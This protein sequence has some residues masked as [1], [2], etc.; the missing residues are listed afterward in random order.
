MA[1]ARFPEPK[2]PPL[3]I[4]PEPTEKPKAGLFRRL[5]RTLL[6]VALIG[7]IAFVLYGSKKI[8]QDRGTGGWVWPTDWTQDELRGVW[9]SAKEISKEASERLKARID[10]RRSRHA[11][12]KKKKDEALAEYEKEKAATG[13]AGGTL[14]PAGQ[15]QF[16]SAI[17]DMRDG[18]ALVDGI[19]GSGKSQSE[20]QADLRQ[21]KDLLTRAKKNFEEGKAKGLTP[22]AEKKLPQFTEQTRSYIE[23]VDSM[24]L[25]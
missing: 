25:Q 15:A 19:F 4:S 16:D 22:A 21:A 23:T 17:V 3:S 9:R 2:R 13:V 20:A 10:E 24:L 18:M 1:D 12:D 6:L 14:P 11:E 8:G 7:A 5:L